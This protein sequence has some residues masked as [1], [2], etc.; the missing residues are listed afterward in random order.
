MS[1]FRQATDKT[2]RREIP[3]TAPARPRSRLGTEWSC[4]WKSYVLAF[5]KAESIAWKKGWAAWIV[6][7]PPCG[8]RVGDE[9]G[10]DTT[11]NS[12]GDR[13]RVMAQGYRFGFLLGEKSLDRSLG[14]TIARRE[15]WLNGGVDCGFVTGGV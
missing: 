12:L 2:A 11:L 6:T 9:R 13:L 15:S 1:A 3:R 8:E 7:N 10:A 5:A 4:A 14:L